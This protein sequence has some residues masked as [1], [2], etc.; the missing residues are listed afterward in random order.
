MVSRPCPTKS[1]A[2]SRLGTVSPG[3]RARP[4]LLD[5]GTDAA[6]NDE[7]GAVMVLALV[8]LVSVSLIVTALLGLVGTSVKAT[9]T[10]G[11]ERN[12]EAAATDAVN[13]AIQN[14]RYSF[15]YGN[16]GTPPL[17]NSAYPDTP[18]NPYSP[19]NPMLNNP[20]PPSAR[21]IRCPAANSVDVYCSMVWQPYS[22]NTR[23]FTYSA[24][25]TA[26]PN[27]ATPAIVPPCPS[28][29]RSSPSTT[30]RPGSRRRSPSP[31]Q[32]RRS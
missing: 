2:L 19:N 18:N 28:S 32:C 11:D 24:C 23:V 27:N 10:F 6:A 15:D 26:S 31:S 5:L 16:T 20:T 1:A 30:I 14:T 25:S 12:V 21:P 13:L 22:A 7:S 4:R 29:R 17:P 9:G 3:A 8:F